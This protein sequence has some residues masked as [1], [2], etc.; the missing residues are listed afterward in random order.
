MEYSS[1]LRPE[2]YVEYRTVCDEETHE[3]QNL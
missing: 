3:N 2:Y 1:V